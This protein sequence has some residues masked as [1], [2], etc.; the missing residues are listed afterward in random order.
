MA[1]K[2]KVQ[3]ALDFL[4][5]ADALKIAEKAAEY[6]DFI[7]AGTPLIKAEGLSVVRRLKERF[8]DKIIVADMKTMDTGFLEAEIAFKA[9]ADAVS[10]LGA[11]D[12]ETI[13]GASEAAKKYGKILMVD[14][15]GIDD[16]SALAEKIMDIHADYLVLH[17]GIDQQHAGK[18]AFSVL[19]KI[20]DKR[21]NSKI[22]L[23]G[24]LNS[25]SIKK[26]PPVPKVDLLVI[27]G[28]ITRS[29]DPQKAAEMI[30]KAIN[31]PHKGH[32]L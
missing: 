19:A 6:A 5:I 25:Y 31:E 12:R 11:A 17:T 3:L 7:E 10:V 13:K 32:G 27:G 29:S 26:L 28:A 18:S 4:T 21:L 9:G 22:A 20:K 24:G 1:E 15:I 30:R 23:C 2:A 16:I 14:S 8:P